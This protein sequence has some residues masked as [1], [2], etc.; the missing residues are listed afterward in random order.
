MDVSDEQQ[1][2]YDKWAIRRIIDG[3]KCHL[4]NYLRC[5]PSHDKDCKSCYQEEVRRG[6]GVS[7]H[8][9]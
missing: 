4:L 8:A 7:L 6:E 9:E 5:I 2:R 1:D 3:E